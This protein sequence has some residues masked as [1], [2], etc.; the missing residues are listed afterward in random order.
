MKQRG[1]RNGEK[2]KKT[3]DKCLD[4]VGWPQ[5]HHLTKLN[6]VTSKAQ[7]LGFSFKELLWFFEL[8]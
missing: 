3:D 4:L 7:L 1:G 5:I 6:A 8:L 2:P